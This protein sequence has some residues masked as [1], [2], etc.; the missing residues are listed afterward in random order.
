MLLFSIK[1]Y[2]QV[3]FSQQW[4]YIINFY[5]IGYNFIRIP[6]SFDI[7]IYYIVYIHIHMYMYIHNRISIPI[8]FHVQNLLGDIDTN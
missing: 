2:P 6:I 1:Y 4:F 3:R 5:W 8:V 7:H